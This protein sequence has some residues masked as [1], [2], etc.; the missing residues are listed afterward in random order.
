MAD[1]F[2]NKYRIP[3]A[4]LKTWNYGLAASYFVT[5]CTDQRQN[6]FGEIIDGKMILSEIGKIVETEWIK[7]CEM[8]PDMNLEL[9]A[10]CVMPNHFHAIIIIGNNEFNNRRDAMHRVSRDKEINKSQTESDGQYSRDEKD[11]ISNI[12]ISQHNRDAKH[13]VSTNRF[14][15]QSKNLASVIRGFKSSVTVAARLINKNF[16][17]QTRFHDHIIRNDLAFRK[18]RKYIIENAQNWAEDSLFN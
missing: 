9:D 13:R 12:D 2:Q 7:S 15:P 6:F 14:A 1:K 5:I 4:R 11:R 8:R 17:W 18:I 10:F 3:S 16:K